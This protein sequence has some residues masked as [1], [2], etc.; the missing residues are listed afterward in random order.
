MTTVPYFGGCLCF[1]PALPTFL[2][3]PFFLTLVLKLCLIRLAGIEKWYHLD[4]CLKINSAL[5]TESFPAKVLK[6]HLSKLQAKATFVSSYLLMGSSLF[7]FHKISASTFVH[8]FGWSFLLLSQDKLLKGMN[9]LKVMD[10]VMCLM[11][12]CQS[13]LH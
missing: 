6:L 5:I 3:P 11:H 8:S 13:A 7:Q 10:N 4:I 12:N 1:L 2:T 9:R